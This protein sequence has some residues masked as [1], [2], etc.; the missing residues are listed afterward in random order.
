MREMELSS[1]IKK[2]L[3]D[4]LTNVLKTKESETNS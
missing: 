2:V 1:S 4:T 3:I